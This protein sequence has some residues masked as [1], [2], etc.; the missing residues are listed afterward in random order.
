MADLSGSLGRRIRWCGCDVAVWRLYE[1]WPLQS[2]LLVPPETS[3]N[4]TIVPSRTFQLTSFL[5]HPSTS[6]LSL[7]AQ[8]PHVSRP[9]L[10]TSHQPHSPSTPPRTRPSHMTPPNMT[11]PHMTPST[12]HP[13]SS[14]KRLNSLHAN[15]TSRSQGPTKTRMTRHNDMIS[16]VSPAQNPVPHVNK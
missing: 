1:T 9:H 10:T 8:V 2:P 14:L 13:S 12:R 5:S 15:P 16:S 6:T 11:L 3:V 4:T 7:S